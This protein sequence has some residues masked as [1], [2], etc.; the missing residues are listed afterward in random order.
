MLAAHTQC[1]RHSARH[2]HSDNDAW[3]VAALVRCSARINIFTLTVQVCWVHCCR[4]WHVARFSMWRLSTPQN[5]INVVR[6]I[7]SSIDGRPIDNVL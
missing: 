5:V 1:S 7:G 2:S 3:H 4:G 6:P